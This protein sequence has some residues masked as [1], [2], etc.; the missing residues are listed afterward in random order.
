MAIVR[1]AFNDRP[2]ELKECLFYVKAKRDKQ[3]QWAGIACAVEMVVRGETK[4][5]LLTSTD[6]KNK[7]GRIFAHRCYPSLFK[8]KLNSV[9]VGDCYEDSKFCFIPLDCTPK[10][11]LKLVSPEDIGKQSVCSSFVITK[12]SF[13][14]IYWQ[15]STSEQRHRLQKDTELEES[16]ALGS[17]VLWTDNAN[18]SYMVGVVSRTCGDFLPDMLTTSSL[19]L[20]GKNS[21]AFYYTFSNYFA[22]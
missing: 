8:K 10:K 18:R 7:Q 1:R 15:Y 21:N 12:R 11:S 14:T 16:A 3:I 20:T 6:V 17:P 9:E 4:F 22:L 2:A 19:K 13:K 5:F